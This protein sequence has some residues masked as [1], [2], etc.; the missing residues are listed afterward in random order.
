MKKSLKWIVA[1]VLIAATFAVHSL[2]LFAM[3]PPY[4]VTDS[5]MN[6]PYYTNLLKVQLTG[7]MRKD[8]VAV[9]QSQI[10]Y[11]EGSSKSA[12]TGLS[13][14]S[15]NYTEYHNFMS[16][17][18]GRSYWGAAWC[19]IFATWCAGVAGIP[20]SIVAPSASASPKG[21]YSFKF[22]GSNALDGSN[23]AAFTD[24]A[25]KGG[26][27]TPLPG[28]YIFYSGSPC[29]GNV[30]SM[31]F[32]HVGIVE[33]CTYTYNANGTI[34][35]MILTT[36]EGNTSNK[37]SNKRWTMNP[38]SNGWVY[39]GCYIGCFG[40]PNYSSEER[41]YVP[42]TTGNS[43]DIGEFGG[44]A[45]KDGASGAAVITVQT[46]LNVLSQK[47]STITPPAVTGVFD[48][49][50]RTAVTQYQE[51]L[52]LEVDGVSGP[53]TW[54]SLRAQLISYTSTL[55]SDFVVQDEC[56]LLYKG[57]SSEVELPEELTSIGGG[58]FAGCTKLK[59]L[60]LPDNLTTVSSNAFTGCTN[61][62]TVSYTTEAEDPDQ[63]GK[64]IFAQ[65]KTADHHIVSFVYGP[66]EEKEVVC[67]RYA[68]GSE[69]APPEQQQN[70][71]AVNYF[72]GWYPNITPVT[73]NMTYTAQFV[74]VDFSS[75]P[76]L[77]Y[78]DNVVSV[79]L[80][81]TVPREIGSISQA[82]IIAN[83]QNDIDCVSFRGFHYDTGTVSVREI[84]KGILDIDVAYTAVEAMQAESSYVIVTLDFYV[85][86]NATERYVDIEFST[87]EDAGVYCSMDDTGDNLISLYSR[88]GSGQII[89]HHYG[90][91]DRNNDGELTISDISLILNSLSS[92]RSSPE[93][94][95]AANAFSGFSVTDVTKLLSILSTPNDEKFT[96]V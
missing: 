47:F 74:Y 11:H 85:S 83:Y 76:R 16:K 50:T 52:S 59:E 48:D 33:S 12:L 34:A 56:L 75:E 20:E 91:Y 54:A 39:S 61:L 4:Q 69:P 35:S 62:T 66:Y 81:V 89:I 26:W 15:G 63:L 84:E 7:D 41:P 90:E 73:K 51:A 79:D 86:K 77:S 23:C 92:V 87:N 45:L 28:D 9:A 95:K 18:F 8:I 6:G 3:E 29:R 38:D 94:Y 30:G 71:T 65:A 70:E 96:I 42:V 82:S 31:S 46:A 57:K 17:R 55:A 14:G 36:V 21:S 78:R 58:A 43:Y 37:V 25:V 88:L 40:I 32:K 44:V 13:S 1:L 64:S 27:Y 68:D 53:K 22:Y 60:S 49:P 19:G 2:P 72:L 10:G 93:I 67:T 80:T 5:Y 24:L